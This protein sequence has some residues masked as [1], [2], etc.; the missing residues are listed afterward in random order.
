[1]NLTG[2]AILNFATTSQVLFIRLRS[3]SVDWESDLKMY[4]VQIFIWYLSFDLR[5]STSDDKKG[6]R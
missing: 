4:S 5:Q 1:M 3:K 6:R 2:V